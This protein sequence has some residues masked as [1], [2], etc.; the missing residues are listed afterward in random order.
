M[1]KHQERLQ[2]VVGSAADKGAALRTLL[3]RLAN[4]HFA[5]VHAGER[6]Q[7]RRSHEGASSGRH[8]FTE[9]DAVCSFPQAA[10]PGLACR[11]VPSSSVDSSSVSLTAMGV[12]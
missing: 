5:G 8:S 1:P 6:L 11:L 2:Q 3:R 10:S 7:E 4:V 9:S 12:F